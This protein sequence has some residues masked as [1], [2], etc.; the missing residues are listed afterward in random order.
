MSTVTQ[1]PRGWS[2]IFRG[3]RYE[4]PTKT[5]AQELL[6][7]LQRGKTPDPP[8]DQ[9]P[10]AAEE[11][12]YSEALIGTI[13]GCAV[14]GSYHDGKLY[15]ASLV[16]DGLKVS[17]DGEHFVNLDLE[18]GESVGDIWLTD[19]KRLK[20]LIETG[21]VEQLIAMVKGRST[22]TPPAVPIH[23]STRPIDAWHSADTALWLIPAPAQ[24]IGDDVPFYFVLGVSIFAA[25]ERKALAMGLSMDQ[26]YAL[27]GSISSIV[28]DFFGVPADG[29]ALTL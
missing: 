13:A 8:I 11:A 6:Y 5:T 29:V 7:D 19:W 10:L 17:S 16:W 2:F 20:A 3:E 14:T 26:S 1:T 23:A 12:E 9:D 4:R 25:I 28:D 15:Y 21:I 24:D 18:E 22:A 27:I